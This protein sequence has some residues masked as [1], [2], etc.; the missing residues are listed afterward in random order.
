MPGA[1]RREGGETRR[2]PETLVLSSRHFSA[3]WKSRPNEDV[4]VGVRPLSGADDDYCRAQAARRAWETFPGKL[5]DA[6]HTQRTDVFNDAL[7]RIAISRATCDPNDAERASE[8]W[9][10]VPEE[11]VNVA[12]SREGVK[13]IYDAIERIT[14][15]LSPVRREA[16]D[17][18]IELLLAIVHDRLSRMPDAR[19][20]RVRRLAG[21]LLDECREYDPEETPVESDSAA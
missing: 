15:A 19:A 2:A 3:K 8:I 9:N 17:E 6:N 21:F 14:I 20:A 13:A 11:A 10:G 18:E 7:M 5:D 12:L 1:F 4:C 16:T